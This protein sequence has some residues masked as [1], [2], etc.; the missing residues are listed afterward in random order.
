VS[1]VVKT[2]LAAG[3]IGAE[4]CAEADWRQTESGDDAT[5]VNGR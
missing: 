1:V 5:R 3:R 4:M 2:R